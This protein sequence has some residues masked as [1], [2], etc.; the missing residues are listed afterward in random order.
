MYLS[1]RG[2]IEYDLTLT[3]IENTN[4]IKMEEKIGHYITEIFS[5]QVLSLVS[6]VSFLGFITFK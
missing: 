3:N 2:I 1:W 4:E 5:V 6:R